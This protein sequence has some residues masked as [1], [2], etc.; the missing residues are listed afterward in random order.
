MITTDTETRATIARH[1]DKFRRHPGS[2][3]MVTASVQAKG[4]IF[5]LGAASAVGA[6]DAFT[7]DNEPHGEN[8]FGAF[9]LCGERLL[10]KIDYY[11]KDIRY[12]A[13]DPADPVNTMRVLTIMFASEYRGSS[14]ASAG[15]FL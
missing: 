6:F 2:D 3:W 4:P 7:G 14:P 11:D 1:N 10:W 15:F 12:G 5:V 8:D 13:D 9:E